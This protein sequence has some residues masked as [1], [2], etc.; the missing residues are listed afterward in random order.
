MPMP[1]CAAGSSKRRIERDKP[2][3]CTMSKKDWRSPAST[4]ATG[5]EGLPN[6]AQSQPDAIASREGADALAPFG[7]RPSK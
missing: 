6:L 4:W 1:R 2:S 7:A 3:S 5:R